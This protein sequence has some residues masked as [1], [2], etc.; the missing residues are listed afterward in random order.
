MATNTSLSVGGAFFQ[1]RERLSFA[2]HYRAACVLGHAFIEDFGVEKG[3]RI[4]IAMRN[5]PEAVVSFWA[6]AIVGAVVVPVNAWWQG[7]ELHYALVDSGVR[8]LVAD[9]ERLQRVHSHRRSIPHLQCILVRSDQATYARTY[10][11][12]LREHRTKT[13]LPSLGAK[14]LSPEDDATIFYTSGTTGFPK[15]ALGTHRNI[16][17][18][19]FS[20]LFGTLRALLRQGKPLPHSDQEQ[21]QRTTLLSVPLFHATGCHAIMVTSAFGGNKLVLM[22]RW[23]PEEALSLI[24][25][26]RVNAFG[27]VPTIAWQIIEH[28]QLTK[29]D[30]SSVES[31]SYGGAPAAPE[32]VRRI[33][34]AFPQVSPRTGWGLTETSSVTTQNTGID[35]TQRPDSV[36]MAVPVCDVVVADDPALPY[37]LGTTGEL[38]VRGSNVV[39]GYWGKPEATAETFVNGWLRTGDIGCVDEDGFVYILDRAKDM[40]IRGGENI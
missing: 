7:D 20:T 37:P 16:C 28:P 39:K 33:A 31:I 18:N 27:G 36:G 4:A 35:Y 24:G 15:G 32:L 34:R 3:D 22:R 6:S 9:S 29:T 14:S 26:E 25:K 23:D 5:Y 38:W 8:V 13:Y 11:A 30:T 19:I 21:P 17:G 2:D 40:L 1:T 12:L 10:D